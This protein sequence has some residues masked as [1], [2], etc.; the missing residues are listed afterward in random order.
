MSFLEGNAGCCG[1]DFSPPEVSLVRVLLVS[2]PYV[3]L[4]GLFL[5]ILL[6]TKRA[7]PAFLRIAAPLEKAFRNSL[8]NIGHARI[9]QKQK[10]VISGKLF[11]ASPAA[12]GTFFTFFNLIVLCS[13]WLALAGIVAVVLALV[14]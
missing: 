12:A 10:C 9:L 8:D 2:T 1:A 14:L 11:A 7:L 4:Y 6:A 5:P 3:V 13:F